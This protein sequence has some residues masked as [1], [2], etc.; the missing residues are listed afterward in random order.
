MGYWKPRL[1][2][3]PVVFFLCV[4]VALPVRAELQAAVEYQKRDGEQSLNTVKVDWWVTQRIGLRGSYDFDA[5]GLSA[6]LLYRK[7]SEGRVTPYLGLGV[8]DLLDHSGKDL[9][10]DER[11]ELIAGLEV[12]LIGKL[13]FTAETRFVPL[14]RDHHQEMKPVLGFAL[15]WLLRKAPGSST[16]TE[17]VTDEVT[18]LLAQLITA[19]AGSEPYEGQVAVG[20]VVMNR[21]KSPDYPQTI[22]EIIYEKGQF[23]CISKLPATKPTTLA[24]RAAREA[25]AGADPSCGALFYYNPLTCDPEGLRFFNSPDLTVTVRIGQHIFLKPTADRV[26]K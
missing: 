25:L 21:L 14:N 12:D 4:L 18:Y 16:T 9:S 23:S 15:K 3:I 8:R 20:A 22:R 26:K 24:V 13:S 6:D 5:T 11:V 7:D 10:T 1:A 19:E 2:V 17:E